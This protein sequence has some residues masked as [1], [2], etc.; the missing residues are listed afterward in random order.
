MLKPEGVDQQRDSSTIC[1]SLKKAVLI[2]INYFDH[3]AEL[4][5]CIDHAKNMSV[6]LT[7]RAGYR[8]EDMLILTDDKN[9]TESQPTKGN[10]LKAL[11]WLAKDPTPDSL[12]LYYSGMFNNPYLRPLKPSLTLT[13]HAGELSHSIG[14][15]CGIGHIY[16]ADFEQLG[17]IYD[18]EIFRIV[19]KC[20]PPGVSLT[21]IF[22]FYESSR[23]LVEHSSPHLS[24]RRRLAP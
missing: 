17:P 22:D 16:P 23:V 10:I 12:F 2:G 9:R 11:H 20:L 19:V 21:L 6:Y 13:G 1:H 4:Q 18:D 5:G 14:N 3:D 15:S 7:D 24:R 8:G